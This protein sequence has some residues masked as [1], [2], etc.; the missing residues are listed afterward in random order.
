[1]S[2]DSNA[3]TSQKHSDLPP[4]KLIELALAREE[5]MLSDT[6]ALRVETGA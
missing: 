4:S 3:N 6:G 2:Q 1:M 5:G